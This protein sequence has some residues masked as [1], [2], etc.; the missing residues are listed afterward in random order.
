MMCGH[1]LREVQTVDDCVGQVGTSDAS[2]AYGWIKAA[3]V[4]WMRTDAIRIELCTVMHERVQ[5]AWKSSS[6]AK[7]KEAMIVNGIFHHP[8]RFS[9]RGGEQ[10]DG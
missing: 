8:R 6:E 9:P 1:W 2:G 7:G 5:L 4:E 10:E 3:F